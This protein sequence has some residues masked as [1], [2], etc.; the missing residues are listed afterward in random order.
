[1]VRER[2]QAAYNNQ[3]LPLLAIGGPKDATPSED[4][5][6]ELW[7]SSLESVWTFPGGVPSKHMI[8]DLYASFVFGNREYLAMY[9]F[10]TIY[11]QD[12]DKFINGAFQ[13]ACR[14]RYRG[15]GYSGPDATESD[16]ANQEAALFAQGK[17]TYTMIYMGN[18]YCVVPT[19]R[20]NAMK[21]VQFYMNDLKDNFTTNNFTGLTKEYTDERT[22]MYAAIRLWNI[23]KQSNLNIR[24]V[25]LR[26]SHRI[27]D[28]TKGD[29]YT[30]RG[31]KRVAY[32]APEK[33]S[34]DSINKRQEVR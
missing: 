34:S 2:Q 12:K 6:R 13:E 19:C 26:S 24:A 16:F 22:G 20:F 32:T 28:R 1:M 18:K 15:L 9:P 21:R 4:V 11:E 10:R 33:Y 23:L 14:A 5:S 3:K 31:K 27:S 17:E 7:C 25:S 29:R 30:W 8:H